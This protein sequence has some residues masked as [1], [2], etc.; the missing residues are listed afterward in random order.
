MHDAENGDRFAV[1]GVKH[2][3]MAKNKLPDPALKRST[4]FRE[5]WSLRAVR[6]SSAKY[7]FR[8]SR[9][10]VTRV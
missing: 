9:P 10:N 4:R 7:R 5:H 6:F 8:C 3:V 2:D 1:E